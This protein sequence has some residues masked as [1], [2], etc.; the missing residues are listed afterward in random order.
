MMRNC[1]LLLASLLSCLSCTMAPTKPPLRVTEIDGT[2]F[3]ITADGR[4][5][6]VR[7]GDEFWPTMKLR[8][9]GPGNTI[10]LHHPQA[11]LEISGTLA[12]EEPKSEAC[13]SAVSLRPINGQIHYR[14]WQGS[15]TKEACIAFDLGKTTL[16][17]SDEANLRFVV[18]DGFTMGLS[19]SGQAR[20]ASALNRAADREAIVTSGEYFLIDPKATWLKH[21]DAS[22]IEE[23]IQHDLRSL[24]GYRASVLHEE[25]QKL[26]SAPK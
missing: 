2:A 10:Q 18:I 14:S 17:A 21:A 5:Q 6:P 3:A 16:I 23:V 11:E 12:I 25:L 13:A 20:L 26:R 8:T 9:E 4:S 22:V 1:L 7:E 19:I 15:A 24:D